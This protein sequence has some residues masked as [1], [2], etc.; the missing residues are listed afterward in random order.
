MLL[1]LPKIIILEGKYEI[2]FMEQ[3]NEDIKAGSAMANQSKGEGY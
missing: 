2:G 1:P 3:N